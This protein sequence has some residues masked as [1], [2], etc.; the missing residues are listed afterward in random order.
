MLSLKRCKLMY[1]TRGQ[2]SAEAE[3]LE[4]N[5]PHDLLFQRALGNQ[6]VHVDDLLLPDTVRAVHR[7]QVRLRVPVRVIEDDDVGGGEVDAEPARAGREE[8][9]EL[10]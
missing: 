4:D 9:D 7:L 8:E 2:L 6:P 1:R 10:L 5:V 3:N